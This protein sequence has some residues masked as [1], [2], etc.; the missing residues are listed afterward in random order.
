M[1]SIPPRNPLPE[2]LVSPMMY[3]PKE[4]PKFPKALITAM[5]TAAEVPLIIDVLVAQ[6]GPCMQ[7]V[8]ASASVPKAKPEPRELV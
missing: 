5:P 6:K 2:L 4:P 1:T 8:A 3:D 7:N